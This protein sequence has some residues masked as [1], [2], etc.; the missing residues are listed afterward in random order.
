MRKKPT[1]NPREAIEETLLLLMG[2]RRQVT[3]T[4]PIL[5]DEANVSLRT[6]TRTNTWLANS[7]RWEIT[8]GTGRSETTYRY[9]G[10]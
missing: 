2:E 5:A 8:K 10:K 9:T 1:F 6:V 4:Q 7:G 3:I